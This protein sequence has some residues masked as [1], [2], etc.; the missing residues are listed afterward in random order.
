M[1]ACHHTSSLQA[2][3]TMTPLLNDKVL[4]TASQHDAYWGTNP[5]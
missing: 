4:Q 5:K 1:E 3:F 2:S